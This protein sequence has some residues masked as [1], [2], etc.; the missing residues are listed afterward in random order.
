MVV[1]SYSFIESSLCVRHYNYFKSSHHPFV[2]FLLQKLA[3]SKVKKHAQIQLVTEN[4]DLNTGS[5]APDLDS[6]HHKI[7]PDDMMF[8]ELLFSFIPVPEQSPSLLIALP[9]TEV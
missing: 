5:L 9:S 7:P 8:D 3:H 2:L 6:S 1:I 4:Q